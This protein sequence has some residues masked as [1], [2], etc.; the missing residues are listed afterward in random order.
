M[1][2]SNDHSERVTGRRSACVICQTLQPS[3]RPDFGAGRAAPTAA[4]PRIPSPKSPVP[5]T[6]P[7][8]PDPRSLPMQGSMFEPRSLED[9]LRQR[10]DGE[11]S[12]RA[13]A[14]DTTARRN[15]ANLSSATWPCGRACRSQSA[16][17]AQ[18]ESPRRRLRAEPTVGGVLPATPRAR[19]RDPGGPVARDRMHFG[20]P[21]TSC[22]A[23]RAMPSAGACVGRLR[24]RAKDHITLLH[25]W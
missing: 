10:D 4:A 15:T 11:L 7:R 25:C 13:V 19:R 9:S 21:A 2:P 23:R 3:P 1:G 20:I 17:Q 12:R 18:P 16:L 8:G 6:G 5:N 22:H 14:L 24:P